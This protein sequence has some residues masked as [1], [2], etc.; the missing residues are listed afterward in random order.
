MYKI[1][2][3]QPWI[4]N[5]EANHIKRV[6]QRTFLTEDKETKKFENSI[7]KI[8]HSK[9]PVAI[10]NWTNGIFCTLKALNIKKN[11]EVIV[12]N[13]TFIA[14]INAV[15]MSGAKPVV[16]EVDEKNLSINL[17]HLKKII[18]KKTKVIMPV[19]LYGHCCEMN[20]LRTIIKNKKIYIIEDAAQ[21]MGAKFDNKFLGTIG[22]FGGFSFYGNK[23]MTT[24]EGGIVLTNNKKLSKKIFSLKNHGRQTKGI[25]K[26]EEIGYNFMF[27]EMQAAI[28]NIQLLKL[29]KIL[30]K[31]E[32]IFKLYKKN[33]KNIDSI[34]F[35][36]NHK[37]N[38][39]VY[40][41]TNIFTSK[42]KG[43]SNYLKINRIQT[44]EI[45]YPIHLQPC[46]K[47]NNIKIKF[48]KK[49]P[50]S[51]KIY[52]NGLSLPSSYDLS[53]KNQMYVIKK[54]KEFFKPKS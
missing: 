14:T 24:G 50:I 10:S 46:F 19:H 1:K 45:F 53:L 44:R 49:Y 52:N 23:I 20:K 30:K 51:E 28:G 39:P 8:F 36:E 33:L 18:S 9:Y 7:K 16:C 34:Y 6:V 11:D 32:K 25:F 40:W 43:L 26:H 38:I 54:I 2:Q 21:A 29:K 27:T 15:L 42:K 22:T 48:S 4:D 41:F 12:P 13:I 5:K 3:I 35:M 17:D 31:K 47:K 37:K